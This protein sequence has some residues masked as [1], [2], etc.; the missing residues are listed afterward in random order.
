MKI[1]VV[2]GYTLNPG[3]LS[4]KG[5]EALG[6]CD[7]YD[8]SSLA[9]VLKRAGGA[10]I[11]LVNKIVL[12]RETIFSLPHLKYIGVTATGFN[13]VDVS[14]ARERNIPVT[15]VPSY[16]TR[17]VAQ[18]TVALLLELT[19]RVGHHAQTVREGKWSRCPDFCYWDFPL[20]ELA[21]LTLGIIGYGRIG[22]RVGHL[23]RAFGAEV[24]VF[25]PFLDG[26]SLQNGERLV[27]LAGEIGDAALARALR[28]LA[29]RGKA[30]RSDSQ[31][32]A[33]EGVEDEDGEQ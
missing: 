31:E 7:I 12:S 9:E 18:M 26:T 33:L 24:L 30:S 2:D 28:R 23:L 21:G 8:R 27:T 1:V 3:D 15:N 22:R 4:W 5:L 29:R 13:I 19:Q 16:G 17:S 14:A 10:E 20:I 11:V 25:D 32:Q 6:S